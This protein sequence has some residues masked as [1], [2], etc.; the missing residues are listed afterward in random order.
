M[1]LVA[2]FFGILDG[3]IELRV[4][5]ASFF[6]VDGHAGFKLSDFFA[7]VFHDDAGIDGINIHG[8]VEDF[9][10]V[11]EGGE[12]TGVEGAGITVDIE[13]AAVLGAEAEVRRMN[14]DTGGADEIAKGSD[15]LLKGALNFGLLLKLGLE[16]RVDGGLFIFLAKCHYWAPFWGASPLRT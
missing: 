16:I 10:N 9:V 11:D 3:S 7:K 4:T 1:E 8:D 5:D 15:S 12:P 2:E 13:S 6:V 14:F